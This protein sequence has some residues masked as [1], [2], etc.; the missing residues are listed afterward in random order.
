MNPRARLAAENYTLNPIPYTLLLKRF[1][2]QSEA[3]LAG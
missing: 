1:F 2:A 3:G